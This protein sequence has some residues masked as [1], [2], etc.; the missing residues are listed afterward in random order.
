MGGSNDLR[1]HHDKQLLVGMSMESSEY[2]GALDSKSFMRAFDIES[3]YRYYRTCSQV[4]W[5]A[6]RATRRGWAGAR[7]ASA[8]A[9]AASG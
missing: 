2:Y 3:T 5:H 8:I 9:G 1:H 6:A 7:H 4:T